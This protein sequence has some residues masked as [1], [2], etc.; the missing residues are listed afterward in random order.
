M[1]FFYANFNGNVTLSPKNKSLRG[2]WGSAFGDGPSL[3]PDPVDLISNPLEYFE[4]ICTDRK[5]QS[6]R[7]NTTLCTRGKSRAKKSSRAQG[8]NVSS[9][10]SVAT[11]LV[12]AVYCCA[13]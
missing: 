4:N 3:R 10:S 1:Y 8:S 13:Q 2:F 12:P 11:V 5:P 6:T 9:Y 7:P